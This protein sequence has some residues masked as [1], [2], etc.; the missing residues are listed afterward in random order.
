MS[1]PLTSHP[2]AGVLLRYA[3]GELPARKSR[4]VARHL[5]ACWQCRTEIEDLQATVAECMRYRKGVLGAQLPAPPAQWGDLSRGFARV[6]ESLATGSFFDRFLRQA[7]VLRWSMA[8]AAALALAV[9]VFYELRE[10][11]SVQAATLLQ[12]AVAASESRHPAARRVRFRSGSQQ[13]VRAAAAAPAALPRDMEAKFQAAHYDSGDPL[14]ARAFRA[15]RDNEPRKQDEVSTVAASPGESCYRIRTVAPEGE[16]ATATLTLRVSDLVPVEGMLQFRDN[17]WIEFS[18]F[19]ESPDRSSDAHVA[20]NVEAPER[21][22]VPPSRLAVVPPRNSASVSDELQVLSALHQIGADLGDPIQVSLSADKVLVSG[23]GVPA[24]QRQRI[25]RTLE[26]MPNVAVQ[27]TEPLAAPV[28]EGSAGS[29]PAPSGNTRAP[30]PNSRMQ[31]R[32]EE[33][34]G[35]PAE[36]E[37]F[38]SQILDLDEAANARAF[39]LR[40]LARRFPAAAETG[41]SPQDRRVLREIA[42]QNADTLASSLGTLE[43]ALRPLLVSLGGAAAQ[44]A[45]ST[46]G[47][48]QGSTEDLVRDT[49]RV[50]ALVSVMLGLAPGQ[51]SNQLPSEVLAALGELRSEL[52]RCRQLLAQEGGG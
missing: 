11:P 14:S 1:N 45:L 42:R 4:Q 43:H 25:Q 38:S 49:L 50:Q 22:A 15:W 35:G 20:S 39:A 24:E 10:T 47:A 21:L 44:P 3:D 17:Q 26:S 6:D 46:Q 32:L 27:F 48:W 37:R 16:V 13:F 31:A 36:F 30:A 19:T 5:E 2:D 9:G 51:S 29:T 7:A 33:Q 34:L 40:S 41:L 28:P 8:A 23:T 52:D 12:R 18:E